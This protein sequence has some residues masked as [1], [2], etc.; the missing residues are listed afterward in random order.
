[1][2]VKEPLVIGIDGV[3]HF[4]E[5]SIA[6]LTDL[7]RHLGTTA[8]NER[9]PLAFALGYREEGAAASLLRELT[10]AVRALQHGS[11][12]SLF[13]LGLE[14]ALELYSRQG[15]DPARVPGMAILQ[16]TGGSPGGI[17]SLARGRRRRQI[18]L[19][20]TPESPPGTASAR[21]P[22]DLVLV[23]GLLGRPARAA[24]LGRLTGSSREDVRRGLAAGGSRGLLR[25]T[26]TGSGEWL[27]TEE[28]RRVAGNASASRRRRVHTRLGKRLAA[29]ARSSEDPCL[30]EAVRHFRSAGAR[31]ELARHGLAAA[32]YLKASYQNRAAI[33]VFQQVLDALPRGALERRAQIAVEIAELYSRTG[34][35]DEGIQVLQRIHSLLRRASS[36][37]RTRIVLWLATLHGRRGDFR[38]AARLFRAGFQIAEKLP[39]PR[40]E[41]LFFL[42]ELA[43]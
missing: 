25:E 21:Q 11:V 22:G 15:G 31:R 32:R 28:G 29:G 30:F 12:I 8:P 18:G 1:M 13:P 2:P 10:G 9:P 19:E 40:R 14:D 33:Q 35:L 36:R 27:A 23:L 34:N 4:D 20:Q 43:A 17:V 26:E 5:V 6:L 24:E 7:L 16:E 38:G 39:L 37:W 42:N 3:Q 41:R